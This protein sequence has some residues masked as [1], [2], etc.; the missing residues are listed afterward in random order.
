MD[1]VGQLVHL[2]LRVNQADW[3][4]E[5]DVLEVWRS[6]LGEAGPY[7]ELT[8]PVWA[9]PRLPKDAADPPASPVTG[10]PV[11]LVGLDLTFELDEK[12]FI[13]IAFAGVDPQHYSDAA[14]T[15]NTDGLG[16]ITSYVTDDGLLVVQGT[17]AGSKRILRVVPSDGAATLGL[18]TT[19]PAC[20]DY[21][22][23]ARIA[24]QS[25]T[26]VYPY[27]DE[28]G[29]PS[30][31]YKS[32]FRNTATGLVSDFSLPIAASYRPPVPPL[33]IGVLDLVDVN[34]RPIVNR[35]VLV[36]GA[37]QVYNIADQTVLPSF[38]Q[39]LTD[40]AGHVEFNL[41]RGSKVTV[42]IAGT[43]LV[44]DIT[45]PTDPAVQVFNLFDP[46]VGK[47]DLFTVQVPD[48]DY[49]VRRTL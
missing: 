35:Q 42:S 22:Q 44:R 41:V 20:V 37:Q 24:L 47:D 38:S 17:M 46:S 29:D 23:D 16:L 8:G 13:H 15:I 33:A 31:F 30:Y 43:L 14:A 45:V 2:D 7:T 21:G 9:P 34:G 19:E 11:N 4:G 6:T 36:E 48:V 5:F 18:P 1:F 12:T 32:R 27:D 25:G 26:L 3:I 40:T 28:H 49:A 39:K 10:P